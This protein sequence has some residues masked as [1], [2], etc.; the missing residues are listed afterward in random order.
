MRKP[1]F[2]IS[3]RCALGLSALMLTPLGLSACDVFDSLAEADKTL[4]QQVQGT[5]A[6]FKPLADG[7]RMAV[8]NQGINGQDML[9]LTPQGT[10]RFNRSENS[11]ERFGGDL[12]TLSS[13]GKIYA[14]AQGDL[15]LFDRINNVYHLKKGESQ[16]Q[17]QAFTDILPDDL[18]DS[19]GVVWAVGNTGAEV[20]AT[21]KA[22]TQSYH[23][24]KRQNADEKFKPWFQWPVKQDNF[25]LGSRDE[26]FLQPNGNVLMTNTSPFKPFVIM[27]GTQKPTP[28]FD[29]SV[30]IN[31]QCGAQ[32]FLRGNGHNKIY[33]V[34]KGDSQTQVYQIPENAS[35]PVVPEALPVL[36]HL[37]KEAE[38]L[39]D[40]KGDLFAVVTQKDAETIPVEPFVLDVSTLMQLQGNRWVKKKTFYPAPYPSDSCCFIGPDNALYHAGFQLAAGAN[41][42]GQ[43]VYRLAY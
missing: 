21:L 19:Q 23:F 6:H 2:G 29:C 3:K 31:K 18:K 16:W 35:F 43:Q 13:A 15:H 7:Y 40:P 17:T 9:F 41:F 30:L 1:Y 32:Q 33:A 11:F 36:E 28:I 20:A 12:P 34:T 24:M 14:D 39:L 8:I 26:F 42:V 27:A 38:I 4:I 25:F 10:V 22:G 37:G 5:Q